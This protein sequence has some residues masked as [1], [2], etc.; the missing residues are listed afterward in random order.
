M[1]GV[2]R[3]ES[4]FLLTDISKITCFTS[5]PLSF[6]AFYDHFP[7][8]FRWQLSFASF[9]PFRAFCLNTMAVPISVKVQSLFTGATI[10]LLYPVPLPY[11]LPRC[12]RCH[13]GF[14]PASHG[15]AIVHATIVI[16]CGHCHGAGD[17]CDRDHGRR[18][19][20]VWSSSPQPASGHCQGEE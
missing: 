2:S 9:A 19:V 10:Q 8:A 16:S 12:R 18:L 1:S 3:R 14:C 6:P 13:R 4:F 7:A 17:C 5:D 11:V 15:T 20:L